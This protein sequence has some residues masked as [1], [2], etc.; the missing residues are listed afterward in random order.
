MKTLLYVWIC[1][2]LAGCGTRRGEVR[3]LETPRLGSWGDQGDGSYRNPVLNG[4]FPDSDVEA[5]D[6]KWYMISSGG[7][8]TPGMTILESEDLVNWEITGGLVDSIGWKTRTGVWAGDFVRRDDHWL[9]Y[10][11]DFETG[12]FVCRADDIRGPWS[13]PQLMLARKGMTDPAV[14]WDEE[15]RQAYLIC[16]YQ[17]DELE[18]ERVYHQRLFRLS[19]DGSRLLDEG[20]D[21]YVGVG[22]E[23]AK[24]Y[25]IDGL[26]YLFIS[27][28]TMDGR[29]NKVDRRQIV[30]RSPSISGPYEKRVLLEKDAVT[31]RSC[32]QG[33]LV[34]VPD[35]SWWYLHQL[36]QSKDS[37]EGRPQF[38]IPVRWEE[39]W[40]LLG[41]DADGNGIGNTVWQAR[42]PVQGKPVR[43]VQTDDDFNLPQM[44][45][46]WRWS[47]NPMPD[48]WS[49][50]ERPGCLRLRATAPQQPKRPYHTLPNRLMLRK[51][52]R[53]TDTVTVKLAVGGLAEGQQAGVALTGLNHAA[54]GV[55]CRGGA[56][57][58]VCTTSRDTTLLPAVDGPWVWLRLCLKQRTATASYSPD[59]RTFHAAGGPFTL[60]T[61][62]F[63]GIFISL[64]SMHPEGL[65]YADFDYFT[66]DYDGPKHQ[67]LAVE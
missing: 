40:P 16:N 5:F 32:S 25:K 58:V 28:W 19:W 51:M 24:I 47:G 39:G 42:K 61:A 23:A 15:E 34:Q 31:Q 53:G 50:T 29:G 2:A 44:R 64:F 56:H 33:A 54:L 9:C 13:A 30:L 57:H 8:L 45:P 55:E 60:T 22:A 21:V 59:G 6:G 67:A 48:K 3:E 43:G 65:G 62:G 1:L 10:F 11:I 52:G 66:Y 35:G 36:V 27:E 63:N 20:Q 49:L 18:K 14:F 41:E 37:Y 46:Q 26:F 12:L 17:I 38:L 7:T 4:N